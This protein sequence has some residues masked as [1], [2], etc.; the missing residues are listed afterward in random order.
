MLYIDRYVYDNGIYH[1]NFVYSGS[2]LDKYLQP[3]I[4][5]GEGIMP[6]FC[7]YSD[8][9]FRRVK[10]EIDYSFHTEKGKKKK[11][12]SRTYLLIFNSQH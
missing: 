5:S 4:R 6:P 9:S 10:I 11:N 8:N 1:A 3:I 2:F 12:S 7:T